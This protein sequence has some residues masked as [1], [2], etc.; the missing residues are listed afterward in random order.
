MSLQTTFDFDSHIERAGHD[1]LA[2]DALGT[3]RVVGCCWCRSE[4]FPG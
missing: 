3:G 1:A 2:L 4:A